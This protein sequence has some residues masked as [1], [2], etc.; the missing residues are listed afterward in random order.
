[1][2]Y[3]EYLPPPPLAPYVRC[4]WVLEDPHAAHGSAPERVVPDG[5]CEIIVHFGSRFRRV[6]D[7]GRA[8][9]QRRSVVA[10][11]ITRHLLLTPTGPAG[12]IGVRFRPGGARPFVGAP[13]H[14]L[15]GDV[16]GLEETWGA[17]AAE[18]EERVAAC[19]D[20]RARVAVTSAALL[21]RLELARPLRPE[22]RLA[23][24]ALVSSSGGVA[25]AELARRV[26]WGRRR[27]ERAFRDE[28]GLSPKVLARV[29]RFQSVVQR[30]VL[31]AATASRTPQ[32]A[33]LALDAGY[34]DQSHMVR[35]FRAFAGLSPTQY[36]AAEHAMADAL[37]AG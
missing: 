10:G 16:L 9:A 8:V 6:E 31:P 1:M 14:E 22:T 25:V 4:F 12:M 30:S 13:V 36:A 26:G 20:D 29:L 35:E 34:A 33:I 19:A 23:V 15:Q 21:R 11:Q 2:R 28:V 3:E 37:V 24:T 32:W 17:D 27:L 7:D 18:L 5:C